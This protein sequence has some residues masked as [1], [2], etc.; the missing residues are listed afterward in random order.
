MRFRVALMVLCALLGAA[1]PAAAKGPSSRDAVRYTVKPRDTLFELSRAFLVPARTWQTLLPISRARGPRQLPIGRT[2]DIPR[3]WLRFTPEQARLASFR[4]A[5]SIENG[6]TRTAPAIGAMLAEGARITTGA[7]GFVTLILAD[8]SRIT[9]PSQSTVRIGLLRRYRLADTIDYR[10][11]LER[12]RI[13]TKVTPITSPSGR[14]HIDTPLTMTAVRG[15]EFRVHYDDAA[16]A[17]GTEVLEG[18]VEVTGAQS[19]KASYVSRGNGATSGTDGEVSLA[20]LLPAPALID[21]GKVQSDDQVSF[22]VTPVPGAIAYRARLATDAGFVDSFAEAS[23]NDGTFTLADV[24]SG[25]LFVRVSP[26]AG[27]GLEGEAQSYA[28]RRI[29]ASLHGLPVEHIADSY[30]FRWYGMGEGKRHYRLQVMQGDPNSVPVVDEVGLEREE[31]AVHSLRP[32]VYFWRVQLTQ[33][34]GDGLF[35]TWTPMDRFVVA[36]TRGS[37]RGK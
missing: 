23:S 25:M 26:I 1:A 17:S 24:P 2:L 8:Q 31:S 35:Q 36:R 22:K 10:F 28:F 9:L 12:G 5:V 16:R 19:G 15:T 13:D 37:A 29:L 33:T 18:T 27:N 14:Y 21:P 3:A 6:G 20:S 4:G 11:D 34:D 30:M 32:G 7:N